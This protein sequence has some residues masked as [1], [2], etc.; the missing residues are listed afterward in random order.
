VVQEEYEQYRESLPDFKGKIIVGKLGITNQRNFIQAYFP[1]GTWLMSF[2]DDIEGW[3]NSLSDRFRDH[4][5]D[6][7]IKDAFTDC[8]ADGANIWSVYPVYN[9]FFRKKREEKTLHATFLMGGFFGL[10]NRNDRISNNIFEHKEDVVRSIEYFVKDG[11]VIRYNRIGCKTIMYTKLGGIGGLQSRMDGSKSVCELIAKKYPLMGSI[12]VR[13]NGMTE[14]KIKKVLPYLPSELD[15]TVLPT[16][17]D[18]FVEIYK[19]LQ[20]V[21]ISAL[22][23]R[24]NR[25]GFPDKC[26]SGVFGMTRGRFTGIYGESCYSIKYPKVSAELIRIGRLL[27]PVPFNSVFVNQNVVCPKHHDSNNIGKS[28]L[29]SFG[30]YTGCKIVVEGKEYDAKDTPICFN[31]AKLEHWNTPDLVG[32]KY[33]IVYYYINHPDAYPLN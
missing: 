21:K 8:V 30:E 14:W 27:C 20:T 4:T 32:N 2:D 7:F 22:S 25:R 1:V 5:F 9:P 17:P 33:S 12:K 19:L 29:I 13:K 16:T 11:R 15:I 10:V 3:D 31:G 24:S 23:A 28:M 6:Q 26:K 18:E